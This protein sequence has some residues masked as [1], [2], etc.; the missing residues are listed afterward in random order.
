MHAMLC[1]MRG[2]LW[3]C[4]VLLNQI[5]SPAPYAFPIHAPIPCNSIPYSTM[6]P[7]QMLHC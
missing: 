5:A 2:Y 6:I 4:A 7:A 1:V 3:S